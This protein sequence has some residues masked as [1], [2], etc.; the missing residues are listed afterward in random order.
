MGVIYLDAC[1][2]IYAV[3]DAERGPHVRELLA[4]RGTEE[5]GISP[6][7]RLE[8]LVGPLR[9]GAVEL[10]DR[11]RAALDL[12]VDLPLNT[13]VFERATRLRAASALRTPDALHLAA[14][15]VHGC[16]ELWTNDTRLASA[17]RGLAVDV[18]RDV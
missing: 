3:E 15:Q 16:D 10:E 11:Y 13:Q 17:S 4:R 12:F 14:A 5:F 6:L 1:V 7:V 18:L 9:R 2:V 8:C